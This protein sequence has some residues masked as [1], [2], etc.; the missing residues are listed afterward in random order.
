MYLSLTGVPPKIINTSEMLPGY[1]SEQNKK[2]HEE[3]NNS[4]LR[5]GPE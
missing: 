2:A 1:S 5:A 3:I 4:I